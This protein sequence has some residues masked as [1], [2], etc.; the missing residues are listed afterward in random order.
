MITKSS[1]QVYLNFLNIIWRLFSRDEFIVK[2]PN[3]VFNKDMPNK[4][5]ISV[6]CT[7][8]QDIDSERL[9]GR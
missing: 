5:I 2:L 7:L 4:N 1:L 9:D 3:S 8:H 6:M